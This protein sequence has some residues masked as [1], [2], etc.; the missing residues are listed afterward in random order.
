MIGSV[1]DT[2][3]FDSVHDPDG[4]LIPETLW[5]YEGGAYVQTNEIV[6]GRGFWVLSQYDCVITLCE[7]GSELTKAIPRSFEKEAPDWKGEIAI[8]RGS[9][10]SALRFGSSVQGT[11]GFD[12]HVDTPLP[13]LVPGARVFSAYFAIDEDVCDRLRDDFRDVQKATTWSLVVESDDPV[14]LEWDISEIPA[15]IDVFFVTESRRIDMREKHSTGLSH[16]GAFHIRVDPEITA[17][18]AYALR[19]CYPNPF[20]TET[21]IEF[22]IP[23]RECPVQTT[24]KIYNIAGQE[25]KK[26]VDEPKDAGCYTVTWDG[27]DDNGVA[28]ATGIYFCRLESGNFIATRRMVL[29]K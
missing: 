14:E 19:P 29:L 22:E 9:T 17:P 11:D 1:W 23:D 6:P 24:L 13:P 26:I 12:A 15:E 25:V 8:R 7:G 21:E 18:S 28:T 27:T 4:C 10:R 16:G 3:H 2:V 5:G 20:N